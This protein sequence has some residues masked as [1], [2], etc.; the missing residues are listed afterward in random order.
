VLKSV[1]D[2]DADHNA[3]SGLVVKNSGFSLHAGVTTNAT[4]RDEL[5]R[6]ARY[7]A[8]P[9]VCEE[10]LSTNAAG[11]VIYRFKKSWDDG[12]AALK[13]TP[14]E[15][16]ERLAALVPRPRVHLTRYSGVLAP[17]YKFRR[18]IVPKPKSVPQLKLEPGNPEANEVDSRSP[19][20]AARG[21]PPTRL[22]A[23]SLTSSPRAC[24]QI[25]N[26]T[27]HSH[28]WTDGFSPNGRAL[29]KALQLLV[30]YPHLTC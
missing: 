17:H 9:A 12:T 25:T 27:S 29:P 26:S 14:L 18:D 2:T 13:M 4:E 5:E 3:S 11:D 16:M 10:R 7:I 30:T 19:G 20:R 15:F 24:H 21:P 6:I 23:R 28:F 8:R 1:P 22:R